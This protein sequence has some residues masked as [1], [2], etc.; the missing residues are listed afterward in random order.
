MPE[1]PEVE[2]VVRGL[3]PK[4][5][6]RKIS[7]VN[8]RRPGVV[9]HGSPKELN[10]IIGHEIQSVYRRSKLIIFGLSDDLHL[11]THLRMTGK[12]VYS[13]TQIPLH[14]HDRVIFILDDGASLHYNDCRAIGKIELLK[15]DVELQE[16]NFKLG[17]EPLSSEYKDYPLY[18]NLR[19][20]NVSIKSF[21][22]NSAYITGLGNIYVSEVLARTGIR[23]TKI[24]N[25]ISRRKS[26]LLKKNIP[27]LLNEAIRKNGTSIK[28]FKKIDSKNGEFQDFLWVYGKNGQPCRKC[29][30]LICRIVQNQ[31]SSFYCPSCQK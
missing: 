6:G 13:P 8:V 14:N 31:R 20:R 18:N 15:S 9:S 3:Q 2:V 11:T 25:K 29:S 4:L 28:D 5:I 7:K 24:T 27:L 17:V 30:S 12:Y 19:E 21:L 1:L 10:Q 23:P 26:E 22:M 16:K